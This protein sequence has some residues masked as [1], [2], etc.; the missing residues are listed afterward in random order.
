MT[1]LTKRE[2]RINSWNRGGSEASEIMGVLW[3]LVA[4]SIKSYDGQRNCR[5]MKNYHSGPSTATQAKIVTPKPLKGFS[6]IVP[7]PAYFI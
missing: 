5:I 2:C 7:S 6:V 4:Y 1:H 3:V